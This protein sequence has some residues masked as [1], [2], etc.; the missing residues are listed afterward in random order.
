LGRDPANELKAGSRTASLGRTERRLLGG[1]AAVQIALTLALLVGAGLLIRTVRSLATIRPGYETQNILTMSVTAV[2]TNWYDFHSRAIERVAA[3]P[4]VTA[5]AFGWGVPLTGNKWNSTLEIAG[6]TSGGTAADRVQLPTKG[7][8]FGPVTIMRLR[9]WSSSIRQPPIVTFRAR[10]PSDGSSGF[11]AMP[12][13]CSKSS[14]FSP[15]PAPM[16]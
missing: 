4:G 7:V 13:T 12:R 3:L 14:A 1:V 16:R 6:E 8:R 2:G 5:A 11:R 15:T 10:I 9:W